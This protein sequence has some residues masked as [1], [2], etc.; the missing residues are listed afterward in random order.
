MNACA[1][2]PDGECVVSASGD[3]TLK[4]WDLDTGR[5]LATLEGHTSDVLGCAVTRDGQYVVSASA[6]RTVK[7]WDLD[8]HACVLTHRGEAYYTA[9]ATLANTIVAGD[10]GGILWFLDWPLPMARCAGERAGVRR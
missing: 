2:T 7:V 8:T 9:V 5:V 4:V 6:D 10:G 1:E 3:G